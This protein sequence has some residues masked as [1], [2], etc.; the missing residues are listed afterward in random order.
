MMQVAQS[1]GGD[2]AARAEAKRCRGHQ[3]IFIGGDSNIA[4]AV[5]CRSTMRSSIPW[6]FDD[7]IKISCNL[8]HGTFRLSTMSR[9]KVWCDV[10]FCGDPR[11]SNASGVQLQE[12]VI[13]AAGDKLFLLGG[14]WGPTASLLTPSVPLGS[15]LLFVAPCLCL[16]LARHT[17]AGL[18]LYEE[19]L[20]SSMLSWDGQAPGWVPS[21][22]GDRRGCRCNG[23]L[24]G[25][26]VVGSGGKWQRSRYVEILKEKGRVVRRRLQGW[27]ETSTWLG[28]AASRNSVTELCWTQGRISV[29]RG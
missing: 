28:K 18:R 7:H 15:C 19:S 29:G 24:L 10:Q 13:Q 2:A 27:R 20:R 17:A 1:K 4:V 14:S 12:N 8:D 23:H 11:A 6:W 9:W 16:P 26:E 5:A 3:S 21:R 22:S 25:F